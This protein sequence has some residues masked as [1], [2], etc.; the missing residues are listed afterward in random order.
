MKCP[1]CGAESTGRFCSYCGSELP[2]K[3]PSIHIEH[4]ETIINNY[5]SK[6][7]DSD[8]I[9]EEEK[10]RAEVRSKIAKEEKKKADLESGRIRNAHFWMWIFIFLIIIVGFFI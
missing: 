7:I 9:Y 1:N 10:L 8:S 6:I 2:K 3:E 5:D 4:N